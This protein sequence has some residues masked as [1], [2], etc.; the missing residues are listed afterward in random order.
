MSC[1]YCITTVNK[2]QTEIDCITGKGNELIELTSIIS[3][4][5]TYLPT[6]CTDNVYL[7]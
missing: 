7:W 6:L 3:Q 4:G 2:L 1:Q 5:I